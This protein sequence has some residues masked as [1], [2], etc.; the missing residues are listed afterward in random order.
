MTQL[1]SEG[2]MNELREA[3]NADPDVKDRL[4]DI[5]FS[6]VISCGF[7][8]EADPRGVFVVENGTCTHAGAWSGEE[9]NWDMRASHDDW[10]KWTQKEMGIAGL[11][12]AF[13]LG[14]LKF[15]KGDFKAMIRDPR[16]AAPFVKSFALM[17]RIGGE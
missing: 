16:M 3:W 17:S 7:K 13:T 5:H 8:D 11:T 1:F 4:A 14:K 2:W 15:A 10:L 6:S 12:M 9:P